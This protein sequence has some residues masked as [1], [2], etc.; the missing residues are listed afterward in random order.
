[1]SDAR[2]TYSRETLEIW[3]NK[4]IDPELSKKYKAIWFYEAGLD[5]ETI[6]RLEN[7]DK[8]YSPDALG[9]HDHRW[10]SGE[11]PPNRPRNA[12]PAKKCQCKT[13]TDR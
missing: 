10:K 9:D 6:R 2:A 1:M 4:F 13:A 5:L 3:N 12:L 8:S 7:G 11:T